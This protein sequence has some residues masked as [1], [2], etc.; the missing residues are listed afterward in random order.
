MPKIKTHKGIL[1]RVKKTANG[2]LKRSKAFHSHIM[3][4]KSGG[5]KRDL[6]QADLID[7]TYEKRYK[8]LLPYN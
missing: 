6:R 8:Q 1:K 2:K 4:K 7:K 3:T 5:K